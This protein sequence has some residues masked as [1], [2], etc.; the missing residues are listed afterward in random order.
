MIYPYHYKTKYCIYAFE[1]YMHNLELQ[2]VHFP[3]AK[4]NTQRKI[5][6]TPVLH[7]VISTKIF[8]PIFQK[9]PCGFPVLV[10]E[11]FPDR[12]KCMARKI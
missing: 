6:C 5:T 12:H 4:K 8:H 9:L 7:N 1:H 3:F 2:H 11:C 10:D